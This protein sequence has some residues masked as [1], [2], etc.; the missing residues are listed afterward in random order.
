MQKTKVWSAATSI[1]HILGDRVDVDTELAKLWRV[2]PPC[3]NVNNVLL[4]IDDPE[5]Y[6]RIHI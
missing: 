4:G 6:R 2:L 3:K 5:Y 1:R